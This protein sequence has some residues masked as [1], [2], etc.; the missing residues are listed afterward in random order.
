MQNPLFPKEIRAIIVGYTSEWRLLPW[1]CENEI[2]WYHLGRNGHP[3]AIELMLRNLDLTC[4]KTASENAGMWPYMRDHKELID[5]DYIDSNPHPEAWEH[6]VA[7]FDRLG[8]CGLE[9]LSVTPH[10]IDWLCKNPDYINPEY[11]SMN[12]NPVVEKLLMDDPERIHWPSLHRNP[13]PWAIEL[14]RAN[15]DKHHPYLAGNPAGFDLLLERA[16]LAGKSIEEFADWTF[17]SWNS[18]PRAVDLVITCP[19]RVNWMEYTKHP[20]AIKYLFQWKSKLDWETL[21]E[22][23]GIFELWTQPGLFELL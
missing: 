3:G 7:N 15:P 20:A 1:L 16:A 11:L 8:G 23:P 17:L 12:P 19:K 6:A 9:Y 18:N 21:W 13:A 10:T 4:W 5:Y 14:L 22:N 2:D